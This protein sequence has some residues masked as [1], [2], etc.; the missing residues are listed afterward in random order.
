MHF[1]DCHTHLDFKDFE[2]DR[3]K[4]LVRAKQNGLTDIIISAT[5]ANNWNKLES[6]KVIDNELFPNCH[7]AYGLH[8]MFIQDHTFDEIELLEQYIKKK[9]PIAIGEI[10][11]DF[12]IPSNKAQ[13]QIQESLFVEQLRL[14]NR[15]NLPVIIHARKSLDIILKY[16][17][18]FSN[19]TGLIHSFSGSEQQ[20]SQLIERGFYL[21]FGGPITYSRATKLRNIVKSIPM[22]NLLLETDS[23]DQSDSMHNGLRNEPAFILEIAKSISSIRNIPLKEV[24]TQTT[25][26]ANTLFKL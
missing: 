23:P 20:A 10:G 18:R 7:V 11:L 17:R 24:A 3:D 4:V 16:L 19:V 5:I 25:S 12:Y 6:L 9:K 26:N 21:S 13:K 8:P 22:K 15:Y 14:A 1:I 2:H